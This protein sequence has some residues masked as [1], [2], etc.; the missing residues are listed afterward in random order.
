MKIKQYLHEILSKKAITDLLPDKK[1]YFLHAD[2]PKV[3][4]IEYE[5]FN[6][7]GAEY[8]ENKEMATEYLIQVDIFATGNYSKIEDA[9]YTAMLEAGFTRYS[10][11]DLFEDKKK[12]NHKAFRFRI[13]IEN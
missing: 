9:V 6:A 5:V 12:L 7:L 3:P 2:T 8:A 4:Y 10:E 13:T 11:A 1:V